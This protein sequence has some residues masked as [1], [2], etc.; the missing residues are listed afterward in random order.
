M[1]RSAG[2]DHERWDGEIFLR[3]LLQRHSRPEREV[4]DRAMLLREQW[5]SLIGRKFRDESQ[6]VMQEGMPRRWVELIDR[7]DVE[8]RKREGCDVAQAA[9]RPKD[10]SG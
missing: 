10:K 3:K 6:N 2:R 1:P 9:P 8:E 4:R 5:Y 7:L